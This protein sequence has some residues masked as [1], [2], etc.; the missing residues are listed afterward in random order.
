MLICGALAFGAAGFGLILGTLTTPKAASIGGPIPDRSERSAVSLWFFALMWNAVSAP[1]FMIAPRELAKGNRMALIG[2]LFPIIGIGL[3]IAAIRASAEVI[4]FGESFLIADSLPV[5]V[6]GSLRGNVLVHKANDVLLNARS[7]TAR[8]TCYSRTRRGRSSSESIICRNECSI[9]D[10]ALQRTARGLAI[11]VVLDVPPEGQTTDTSNPYNQIYWKLN[12]D[13]DVPG[14]DYNATFEVPVFGVAEAQE[15]SVAPASAPSALTVIERQ[16]PEGTEI[17]FPP[18]RARSAAF[19][20]LG[21]SAIWIG[22]IVF[23]IKL[24]APLPFAI[25]FGLFELFFLWIVLDLFFG[26]SIV[27][28]APDAIHVHRSLLFLRS[29]RD[30]PRADIADVRTKIGVQTSGGTGQP[31][32][33]VDIA[34]KNGGSVTAGKYLTN[35]REAEWIAQQ[36]LR[37]A[38]GPVR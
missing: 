24:H 30:I 14:V 9:S 33:E 5:P 23:M 18:F 6:G 8:L 38:N 13:A 16:T 20:L 32:Y 4:R 19:G 12:V 25:F 28:I 34:L 11:P 7:I 31:Y 21:F 17:V 2:F 3:A 22:A 35:K 37:N 1:I 10:S 29:D 15:R 36:M 27:R 26:S